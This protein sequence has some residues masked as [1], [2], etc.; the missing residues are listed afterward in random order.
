ME[1][2]VKIILKS[3]KDQSVLRRHPWIFSG[4]IKK[5]YGDPADGDLV[6]VFTN[7]DEPIAL[8]HYQPG[9]I[10]VR[11]L[12]FGFVDIDDSFWSD[13]ISNAYSLRKQL[14]LESSAITNVYRLVNAEGDCLPGLV[15]DY[16]NGHIVLQMH[17]SGMYRNIR[18]I[19]RALERLYNDRI[20]SIF[21]KSESTMPYNSPFNV[22]NS[23]LTGNTTTTTVLEN[24]LKF[25]V[26]WIDG[27]KTGFYIDQRENRELLKQYS[28]HK[29]VLNMFCYSG[30]F[31]VYALAGNAKHVDSVDSSA[32]AI[33]WVNENVAM[34]FP[35]T[36]HKSYV[37]DCFK[38]M[39]HVKDA[40]DLI[41][42]DPPAFA[43]HQNVLRNALQGYKR[44]NQIALEQIRSGGILF[45]FS[46]S[47]VVSKENFRKSVFAAAANVKRNI[48]ILHQLTQP[49]DHPVNIF[50]PEGEYLK[51]LVLYVD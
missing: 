32:K 26:D 47:Q 36:E 3:G 30:G 43:K 50:H 41:I 37:D 17:S 39:E 13:R 24:N 46:C 25:R 6:Q 23:F 31:S 27:Q 38:F 7:K 16:Y 34:N 14:G 2:L 49:G 35:G 18:S 40:Y 1:N 15:I 19:V 48:R 42:L 20:I 51:G 29:D 33:D 9:S 21:D 4:A 28:E 5:I 45:T 12:E 44:L 8:G 22:K 10:A 11:I